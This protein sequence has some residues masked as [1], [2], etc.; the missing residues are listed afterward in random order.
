[1]KKSEKR[2]WKTMV[3]MLAVV[4]ALLGLVIPEKTVCAGNSFTAADGFL[5]GTR[6]SQS[7][8]EADSEEY[9]KFTTPGGRAFYSLTMYNV[10]NGRT[11]YMKIYDSP[12]FSGNVLID[13]NMYSSGNKTKAVKLQ[14]NHTYYIYC[15]GGGVGESAFVLNRISDDYGDTFAEAANVAIGS[16]VN[17]RIEVS[18][19]GE[20]DFFRFTTGGGNSFY[21]LALATTGT[22]SCEA[23]IYEGNDASY[24]HIDLWASSGNTDIELPKLQK[25]HTYYVMV[26]GV[27]DASTS[28]KFSVKEVPDEAGDDFADATKVTVNK[29]K[30]ARIQS[31]KDVD[32]FRFTTDK[33]KTAYQLCIKN[34]S[35]G[36]IQITVYSNKD[37]A[38]TVSGLKER[39]ISSATTET[40]PL[41]LKKGR[42]YYVKVT[43]GEGSDY[44][45]TMKD[46]QT[47]I[48]KAKPSGFK[49][50]GYGGYFSRYAY[51]TWKYQQGYSGYEIWRSTSPKKGFKK[52]KTI[53]AKTSS[54]SSYMDKNV[55]KGKTY[56]YKMRYYVKDNGKNYYSKW[57]NAK[58][59]K[60]R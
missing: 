13:L 16:T 3:Q 44:V 9:Y 4:F 48:K 18:G 58:K 17:G 57:T 2:Q 37:I 49:V 36:S 47:A 7:Y 32:F 35:Q 59:A 39:Y 28:Y 46:A 33:K 53:S 56:Y 34:K 60:I 19:E 26:K 22:D 52:I 55:K 41:T 5:L 14:P 6:I 51:L 11:K 21:Q 12:S 31:K 1:M 40:I 25:N 29:G 24:N 15:S 38:S 43:G 23:Y 8:T 27:W 20:K 30:S 50:K 45:L 54:T 42:T 10:S